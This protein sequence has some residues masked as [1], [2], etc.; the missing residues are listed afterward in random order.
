MKLY[1]CS[2]GALFKFHY[3]LV[4]HIGYFILLNNNAD[5][6]CEVTEKP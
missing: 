1:K 3:K 2:C 4:N 5:Y 6:H